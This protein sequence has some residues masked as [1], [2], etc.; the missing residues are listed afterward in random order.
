MLQ[1]EQ[2]C[3]FFLEE[4]IS[5]NGWLLAWIGGLDSWDPLM[6]WIVTWGYP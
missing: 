4:M 3:L 6:K 1:R 5:T 2:I